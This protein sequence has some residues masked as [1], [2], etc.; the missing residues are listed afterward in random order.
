MTTLNLTNQT[1]AKDTIEPKLVQLKTM[2]D[3]RKEV[4]QRIPVEKRVVWLKSNKDPIMSLAWSL[5]KYLDK[6]FFGQDW[7]QAEKMRNG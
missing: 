7:D 6:E 2:L 4:W 1:I 5:Y 3:A